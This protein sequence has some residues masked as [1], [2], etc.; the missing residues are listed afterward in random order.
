MNRFY[1]VVISLRFGLFFTF[2]AISYVNA[3]SFPGD[4]SGRDSVKAFSIDVLSDNSPWAGR[5]IIHNGQKLVAAT[6]EQLIA[7]Q[8]AGVRGTETNGAPG[9]DFSVR[10]R[11]TSTMFSSSE[12][13]YVIDGMPI[14]FY[15][16]DYRTRMFEPQ[17]QPM[18]ANPLSILNPAD[19]ESIEVVK[20]GSAMAMYGS[21]GSNGVIV[22]RTKRATSNG[23]KIDFESSASVQ[24]IARKPGILNASDYIAFRR[25]IEKY[26]PNTLK[27]A[28]I[29]EDPSFQQQG[30]DWVDAVTRNGT[31]FRNQLGLSGGTD[32]LKFSIQGNLTDQKGVLL[33]S[34]YDRKSIRVNLDANFLKNRLRLG[35]STYYAT[36]NAQM[37]SAFSGV[38]TAF[39][40]G[41][42]Y[43]ADGT[44]H[45]PAIGKFDMANPVAQVQNS[46]ADSDSRRMISSQY[47]QFDIIKSLSLRAQ[48][49][50]TFDRQYFNRVPDYAATP[51]RA[52]TDHDQH[53]FETALDYRRQWKK[54]VLMVAASYSRQDFKRREALATSPNETDLTRWI[55]TV[56]AHP[57]AELAPLAAPF[58]YSRARS[59]TRIHSFILQSSLQTGGGFTF[60]LN[61]RRESWPLNATYEPYQFHSIGSGAAW[62]VP[63]RSGWL[64]SPGNGLRIVADYGFTQPIF[65][66]STSHVQIVGDDPKVYSHLV[67]LG[68]VVDLLKGKLR[69]ELDLFENMA[70]HVPY[71]TGMLQPGGNVKRFYG[72]SRGLHNRGIELTASNK[73]EI[74]GAITGIISGNVTVLSNRVRDPKSAYPGTDRDAAKN[75]PVG[76][77]FGFHS[78]AV[79]HSEQELRDAGYPETEISYRVGTAR[80]TH[81]PGT[82]ADYFGSPTPSVVWGISSSWQW[83]R[84]DLSLLFRGEH[85]QKVVNQM[86]AMLHGGTI[87]NTT[88]YAL[89]NAWNPNQ[90]YINIPRQGADFNFGSYPLNFYLEKAGFIRLQNLSLGCRIPLWKDKTARVFLNAQNLFVLTKYRGWDPEVNFSGQAPASQGYDYGAYPRARTFSAGIQLHL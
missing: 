26:Y 40:F 48:Y 2:L 83:N 42:V 81:P 72:A 28:P 15:S 76:S 85:G 49:G 57:D 73:F 10:V 84:L 80:E 14:D 82:G 12:P 16:A 53:S 54:N 21:R 27:L 6:P 59:K 50:T 33:A 19:I 13:L 52:F 5:R 70:N 35:T 71:Q 75:R 89:Q 62:Q 46:G 22:I 36:A 77:F 66:V 61:A 3:Q 23:L 29:L 25:K 17:W 51:S 69:L 24:R 44:F 7:G 20:N 68:S 18:A 39:P 11:G 37:R 43:N 74:F 9:G 41:P 86:G 67:S 31:A 79:W 78:D 88:Y 38:Y 55:E 8:M 34:G 58:S 47:L 56:R 65:S 87:G 45:R 32:F 4:S 30:I 63:G 60:N 90:P 1:S 64:A